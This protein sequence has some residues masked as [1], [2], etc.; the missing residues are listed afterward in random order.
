MVQLS[1]LPYRPPSIWTRL[2]QTAFR[3]HLLNTVIS[4]RTSQEPRGKLLLEVAALKAA[5]VAPPPDRACAGEWR[6]RPSKDRVPPELQAGSPKEKLLESRGTHR[7]ARPGWRSYRVTTAQATRRQ[8]SSSSREGLIS[9]EFHRGRLQPAFSG[10]T[11]WQDPRSSRADTPG[12]RVPC[13]GHALLTE[14]P[15]AELPATEQGR[16]DRLKELTT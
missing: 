10:L 9:K 12:L 11:N 3:K 4:C 16:S 6:K 14:L 1:R 13:L 7:T 15:S 5:L 2:G 8:E